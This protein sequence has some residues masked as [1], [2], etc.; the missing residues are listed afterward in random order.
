MAALNQSRCLGWQ[1]GIPQRD[2]N[3]GLLKGWEE[4]PYW[5][6][7]IRKLST[8]RP[9][10]GGLIIPSG[11]SHSE[12]PGRFVRAGQQVRLRNWSKEVT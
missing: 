3:L 5:S 12:G 6:I 2:N 9:K 7:Q 10:P 8:S 4:V 1:K 11:H